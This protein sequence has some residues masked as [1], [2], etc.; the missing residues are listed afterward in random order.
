MNENLTRKQLEDN[1]V[2]KGYYLLIRSS[3][4]EPSWFTSE[5]FDNFLDAWSDL[6]DYYTAHDDTVI[7]IEALREYRHF[8]FVL[9]ETLRKTGSGE[10]SYEEIREALANLEGIMDELQRHALH[11]VYRRGESIRD[12]LDRRT[13]GETSQNP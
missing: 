12:S 3:L 10:S 8:A 7:G 9:R 11:N 5:E 1:I 2:E 13:Y 6:M 4:S